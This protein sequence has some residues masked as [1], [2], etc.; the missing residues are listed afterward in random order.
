MVVA[1]KAGDIA[2]P[3]RP[4]LNAP[5]F[6]EAVSVGG[7]AVR[8]TEKSD[9]ER[10]AEDALVGAEPLKSFFSSDGKRLIGD[11][12]FRRPKSGRLHTKNSFVISASALE[13]FARI[14]GMAVR[15]TRQRRARIGDASDVG[16]TEQRKNGMIERCGAEFDLSAL[17]SLAIN[18]Q[19]HLQK[20]Q[21]L[22][23]Q[24]LFVFFAVI[25]PFRGKT[26][27]NL[28]SCEPNLFHPGK[29]RKK[30]QVAPVAWREGN[31]GLLTTSGLRP[32]VKL[33][34]ARPA[35]HEALVIHLKSAGKNFSFVLT[36][37][38]VGF[39]ESERKPG[40]IEF[41]AGVFLKLSSER[42]NDVERSVKL[43]KVSKRLHH[44][45]I[46]FEGMEA[47][48]RQHV[49]ARFRISILRLV[50]VPQHD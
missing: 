14:F 2:C 21:L 38:I 50:H 34:E 32:F 45:P 20:F 24:R 5:G 41:P 29:L 18:R 15:A 37:E 48:P 4:H 26:I 27:D 23:L 40:L 13:L 49:A 6:V 8:I 25:L 19:N 36:R 43:G 28:I 16:I 9:V 11:G 46:I 12:T 30:L 44:A 39:L 3:V 47:G 31:L 42:G 33:D 1:E 17:R 10:A 35:G 22:R 7:D